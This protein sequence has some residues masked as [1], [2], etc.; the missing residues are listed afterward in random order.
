MNQQNKVYSTALYLRLSREDEGEGESSSIS[1]QRI[2][3]RQYTEKNGFI[4]YDEYIDD[5]VSGSYFDRPSLERMQEDILQGRVNCVITKDFSRLGRTA[6]QMLYMIEKFFPEHNVRYIALEPFYDS[7]NPAPSSDITSQFTIMLNQL[8]VIDISHKIRSSLTARMEAGKLVA[9]LPRYGY[10]RDPA[11]SGHI[12]PDET[13]AAVVRE[14]FAMAAEGATPAEI[15]HNF[16]RRGIP[17]PAVYLCQ[18]NPHM[19]LEQRSKYKEW[20]SATICKMLK[21][22]VYIGNLCQGRSK[23]VSHNSKKTRYLPREDW[24]ICEGTHEPLIDKETF[25]L[26]QKRVTS[27]RNP[28]KTGFHSIFRE[29]AKC[30]DCGRAM[31]PTASRKKDEPYKLSCGGYKQCGASRCSNHFIS[32]NTLCEIVLCEIKKWLSLT[33]EEKEMIVRELETEEKERVQSANRNNADK[34]R[35]LKKEKESKYLYLKNAHEEFSRGVLPKMIYDTLVQGYVAEIEKLD[36]EIQDIDKLLETDN[37]QSEAY[38]KFFS[39][40]DDITDLKE[41]TRDVLVKLIDRIEVEQG[42]WEKDENGKKVHRQEIHI[43]Y[44]FIGCIDEE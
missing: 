14:M 20:A 39:L 4:V 28:P 18:K 8:Y 17:T 9:P 12:I 43:Y 38:Q 41:L 37:S 36:K 7:S 16:N 2:L 1:S 6:Y 5:G 23:K 35:D 22:E 26:V 32:Y 34:L 24:I 40:L 3:L 15:A 13:S 27:R 33:L 11:D 30:A 44:K 25:E 42:V 10:Q 19:S 31:S 21:N 29:I